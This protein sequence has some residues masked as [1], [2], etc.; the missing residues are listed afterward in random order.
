MPIESFHQNISSNASQSLKAKVIISTFID[1]S[2]LFDNKSLHENAEKSK[3][4]VS[5]K[6]GIE[7]KGVF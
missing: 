4:N 5:T 1:L 7:N 3:K 2:L 6:K